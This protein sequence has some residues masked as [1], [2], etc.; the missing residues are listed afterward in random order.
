MRRGGIA[1][2]KRRAWIETDMPASAVSVRIRIALWKRRAWI[3][4]MSS[5]CLVFKQKC[6]ALWK[7]RAWIETTK[8]FVEYTGIPHRPLE[9]E[10]VD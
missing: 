1:F 3:E 10:G 7:R 2:W 4:T 6:I 5:A 9:T 8:Y